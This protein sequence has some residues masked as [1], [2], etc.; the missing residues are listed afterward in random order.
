[1][2]KSML[3][4]TTVLLIALVGCSSSDSNKNDTINA[5]KE[6]TE[7]NMGKDDHFITEKPQNRDDDVARIPV[8]TEQSN[9]E[10]KTG[11]RV[12]IGTYSLSSSSVPGYPLNIYDKEQKNN[13]HNIKINIETDGGTLVSWN[14]KT[15]KVKDKGKNVSFDLNENIYWSPICNN[16]I[17][18]KANIKISMYEDNEIIEQTLLYIYEEQEA[19]YIIQKI[20]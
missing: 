15:G 17:A 12:N 13:K 16:V 1:M 7:S 3:F 6:Q 19:N 10:I 20:S 11:E 5:A 4:I 8:V 9:R 18:K 2:K 14:S